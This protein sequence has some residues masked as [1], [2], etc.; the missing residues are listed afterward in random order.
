MAQD[1]RTRFWCRDRPGDPFPNPT[2]QH[3]QGY[4]TESGT[5]PSLLIVLGKRTPHDSP[6]QCLLC[7]APG[8]MAVFSMA[9]EFYWSLM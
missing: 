4:A 9:E 6:I 2:A 7:T 8:T 1:A 5:A 3:D